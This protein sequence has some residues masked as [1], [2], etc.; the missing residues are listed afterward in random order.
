MKERLIK[1]K[2]RSGEKENSI[3]KLKDD[4]FLIKTRA[5]KKEG[6]ANNSIIHILSDYFKIPPEKI[7]IIRGTTSP[8]KIIKI[9]E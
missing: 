1:V 2:V 4:E 5:E 7:V 9:Y 8:S 3:T 6:K